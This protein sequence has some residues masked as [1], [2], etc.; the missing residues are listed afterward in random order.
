[1]LD[2]RH[3]TAISRCDGIIGFSAIRNQWRESQEGGP[4]LTMVGEIQAVANYLQNPGL[5]T[6]HGAESRRLTEL[7]FD[8]SEVVAR[9][10][11]LCKPVKLAQ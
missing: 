11:N 10:S 9:Y 4:G 1:M 6:Y 2:V 3:R 5:M 8:L 7:D